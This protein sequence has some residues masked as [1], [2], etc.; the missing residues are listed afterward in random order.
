MELL[1][2]DSAAPSLGKTLSRPLLFSFY[3]NAPL[4][5]YKFIVMPSFSKIGPPNSISFRIH[6]TWISQCLWPNPI[7]RPVCVL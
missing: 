2:L 4:F 3:I 5:T 7:I 6:G 1:K